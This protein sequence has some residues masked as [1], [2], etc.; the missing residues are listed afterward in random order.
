WRQLVSHS[1]AFMAPFAEIKSA[2]RQTVAAEAAKKSGKS[3]PRQPVQHNNPSSERHAARQRC[4]EG[5]LRQCDQ[6]T[7]E[8]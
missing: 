5:Q 3:G 8:V 4:P 2:Y 1:I 7:S 6:N